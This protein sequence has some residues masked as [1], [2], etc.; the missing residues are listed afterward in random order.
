MKEGG[1]DWIWMDRSKENEG[2]RGRLDM[3][4]VD[5]IEE[6]RAILNT[7]EGGGGGGDRLNE[8]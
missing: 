3:A 8:H 4:W 6:G 5:R 7:G 1:E 2:G